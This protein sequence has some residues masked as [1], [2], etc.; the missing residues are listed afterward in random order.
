VTTYRPRI[1]LV[2]AGLI[3]QNVH[4]PRLAAREDA[5]FAVVIDIDADRARETAE[6]SHKGD[7]L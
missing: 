2:G 4:L 7:T 6:R 5:E 1:A 3:A